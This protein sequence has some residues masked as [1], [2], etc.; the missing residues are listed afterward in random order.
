MRVPSDVTTTLTVGTALYTFDDLPARDGRV[1]EF[2]FQVKRR[3]GETREVSFKGALGDPVQM[4]LTFPPRFDPKRK[5]KLLQSTI[6]SIDPDA[7]LAEELRK[8][9]PALLDLIPCDGIGRPRRLARANRLRPGA[10][11]PGAGQRRC[12]GTARVLARSG[13]AAIGE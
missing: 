13:L 6:S 3:D 10:R 9:I 7:S 1:K 2:E 11:R 12:A 4:F 8:R 5:H